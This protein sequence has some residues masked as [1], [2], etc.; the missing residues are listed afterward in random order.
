LRVKSF[1]EYNLILND[2]LSLITMVLLI[3][4]SVQFIINNELTNIL[5]DSRQR[6]SWLVYPEQEQGDNAIQSHGGAD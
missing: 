2:T 1:K 4:L 3:I 5:N 6:K